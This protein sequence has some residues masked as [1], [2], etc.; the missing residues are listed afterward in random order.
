[1]RLSVFSDYA[2]RV[3]MQAALRTPELTTIDEVAHSFGISRN[4]LSKVVHQLSC[5]GFI[6]TR[7]GIGG[8][9]TLARPLKEITLGEVIRL[10]E[11]DDAVIDCVTGKSRSCVIFPT[12]KLKG[13]LA[14]AAQAFYEVLDNY[15][16]QDLVRQRPA[17]RELLGI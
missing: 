7:R 8:G 14:E 10:T 5:H 3:L 6:S 2:L 13:V 9:F 17:I 11:G 12:C 4:H 16:L 1:M 15:T